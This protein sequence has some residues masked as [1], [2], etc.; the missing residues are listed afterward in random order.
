[1]TCKLPPEP[2][3]NP[4]WLVYMIEASDGRLYTGITNNLSRRF[5]QHKN[6]SGARFFRGR[7]PTTLVYTECGFDRSTASQRE[8]A[9]KKLSRHEKR[10]LIQ[11]FAILP[12]RPQVD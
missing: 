5:N 9:I 7:K 2:A 3:P 12:P 11:Q 8:A 10:H 4:S 6:G 1:M